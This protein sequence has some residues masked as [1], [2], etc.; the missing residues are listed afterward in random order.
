MSY[1]TTVRDDIGNEHPRKHLRLKERGEL[2]L[3]RLYSEG[4][5][6]RA[7]ELELRTQPI[8][9]HPMN[10]RSAQRVKR[11]RLFLQGHGRGV[12]RVFRP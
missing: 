7:I 12:R 3:K 6:K 10:R 4:E 11:R 5:E 2:E 9:D 1:G 8:D